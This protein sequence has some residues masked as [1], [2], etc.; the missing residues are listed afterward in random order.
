MAQQTEKPTTEERIRIFAAYW[1]ANVEIKSKPN[2]NAVW[3]ASDTYKN[4]SLVLQAIELDRA[5]LTLLLHPLSS[6]T[7]EHAIECG[8]ICGVIDADCPGEDLSYWGA[9]TCRKYLI[10]MDIRKIELSDKLREWG[11]N[12]GF[13]KYSASDLVEMGIVKYIV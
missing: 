3:L 5:D 6:I 12:I 8:R 13:G 4:S 7:E 10:P 2:S 11:Y 1:G 9:Y